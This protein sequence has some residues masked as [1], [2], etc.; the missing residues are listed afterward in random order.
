MDEPD[1]LKEKPHTVRSD[2]TAAM[3]KCLRLLGPVL[4]QFQ[5][6]CRNFQVE[7]LLYGVPGVPNQVP[8]W[9]TCFQ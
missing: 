8:E 4:G 2:W 1:S 9:P 3:E 5:W 7:Y 6:G